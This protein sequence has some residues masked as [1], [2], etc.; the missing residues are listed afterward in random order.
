MLGSILVSETVARVTRS[1]THA[2]VPKARA[3]SIAHAVSSASSGGSGS[4]VANGASHA[5]THRVQLDFAQATQ[6]VVYGM[7]A[8]MAVAFIVALRA[9]PSGRA[10]VVED[11]ATVEPAAGASPVGA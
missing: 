10:G 4:S 5:L 8:A 3:E 6:V 7:A 1:L 2:G 11:D 9:M